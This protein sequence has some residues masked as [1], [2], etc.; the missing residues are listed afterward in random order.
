VVLED[1]GLVEPLSNCESDRLSPDHEPP[2]STDGR[3]LTIATLPEP[4]D[5]DRHLQALN[6]GTLMRS[7][8][9]CVAWDYIAFGLMGV[10]GLALASSS[11]LSAYSVVIAASS[12]CPVLTLIATPFVVG[13]SDARRRHRHP[14]PLHPSPRHP[15]GDWGP[16]LVIRQ[17]VTIVWRP[18]A[19]SWALFSGTVSVLGVE[20]PLYRIFI[21]AM[22]VLIGAAFLWVVFRSD[23]GVRLRAVI[24]N[25]EIATAL[26]VDSRR[27]DALTFAGGAGVAALAGAIVA[28]LGTVNPNMGLP[29]LIDSF[30]VV[31]VGGESAIGPVVGAVFVGGAESTLSFFIQPVTA[32]MLVIVVAIIAIR[33]RPQGLAGRRRR[34]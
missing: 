5:G 34:T 1:F 21:I 13:A 22:A 24:Q 8:S 27:V 20:Y 16:S 12:G 10:I 31:I 14:A 15:A 26:G 11:I 33:F 3:R 2:T 18:A 29:W 4:T 7:S 30:L 17:V 6:T 9:S 23:F 25:R 32:S 19:R 28:P